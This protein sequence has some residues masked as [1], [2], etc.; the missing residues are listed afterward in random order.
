[1][2]QVNPPSLVDSNSI[3]SKAYETGI[4]S[5]S[6][7]LNR[8][9]SKELAEHVN[10]NLSGY[11]TSNN[12][13]GLTSSLISVGVRGK[14]VVVSNFTFAATLDAVVLAGGIP[15]V[16][17]INPKTL[18]LDTDRVEEL[19]VD[20]KFDVAAVMPTRVFG[21]VTD[22]SKMIKKCKEHG[23][24]VI[25]D[26]AASFPGFTETWNFESFALYEV[27]SLH[28]TKVFGIGEGGLVV[29]KHEEIE[30]IR[31]SSNF[32]LTS[33][34]T[35]K[36]SDGLNAKADEFTAAR[37]LAR[38]P[39]YLEDVKLRS[40]FVEIYKKILEGFPE[41]WTL[42][43][44]EGTVYSYFPIVF[45][46]EK[47]LYQF[48][49]IVGEFILTRRYYFPTLKSGYIG[50]AKIVYEKDLTISESV[51]RRILCLPVYVHCTDEVKM[52]IEKLL[53]SALEAIN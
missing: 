47:K 43:N 32:G 46:S 15:L 24:P 34:P 26:A 45:P 33:G 53:R 12:T 37:A 6:A 2:V 5:N 22:M 18:E 48:Q 40:E 50:D 1:L 35:I 25:I 10:P 8:R 31:Q 49:N 29:G 41:I 38:F 42:N 19:L 27:F 4:F 23:I 13:M 39:K 21:Y 9:A 14:H 30:K 44:V 51:S 52:E 17:D 16:C 28:A 36:F 20:G 11:L 3:V 7:E